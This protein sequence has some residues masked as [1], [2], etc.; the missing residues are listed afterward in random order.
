MAGRMELTE[1]ST[2]EPRC[3]HLAGEE[4]TSSFLL[5]ENIH[6]QEN[7]I[8]SGWKPEAPAAL[9][10]VG[11]GCGRWAGAFLSRRIA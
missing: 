7:S 8:F 4:E 2:R 3:W 5:G 11:Q 1:T 9:D 10:S 6:T